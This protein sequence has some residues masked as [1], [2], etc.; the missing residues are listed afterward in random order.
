MLEET[1]GLDVL[2]VLRGPRQPP[3][4]VVTVAIDRETAS[5]FHASDEPSLWPRTLHAELV[6]RLVGA[7]AELVAF[8]VFFNEAR[9]DED[10]RLAEAI[11]EAG[12]VVLASFLKLKH[13]QGD[14]YVE[15]LVPPVETLASGALGSAPILLAQGAEAIRFLT[16]HGE[17]Q[18]LATWPLM[19]VNHYLKRRLQM[20]GDGQAPPTVPASS[21]RSLSIEEESTLRRAVEGL[22]EVTEKREA[23]Y[24]N[25]YGPAG[26]LTR[27]S[28]RD[29]LTV[30]SG[31][32][33]DLR[34]KI[35]VVGFGEDFQPDA[36]LQLGPYSALSSL[37]LA[38]TAVANLLENRPVRPL[39]NGAG[40]TLLLTV[41]G[42]GV[43][44]LARRA[45][46]LG[47]LG[48][49]LLAG[50]GYLGL[51]VLVFA[52]W[53]YWLPLMLPLFWLVPLGLLSGLLVNYLRHTSEKQRLHTAI[54]RFIPVEVAS[55]L[56][57]PEGRQDWD[58]RLRFGV[59]MACDAGQYTALAERMEPMALGKLMNAY[60]AALFPIM[61]GSG[62]WVSDVV[63]DAMMAIWVGGSE[64]DPELR[65]R[66]L[67]AALELQ[68][69]VDRFEHTYAVRL[70][71]RIGLHC[72][73]MRVGFIGA[74]DHGEYRAMGDTVN[75]AAR[76]E[77]LNKLLG[78]R[79]LASAAFMEGMEHLHR[80]VGSF[81]L[82]G[83]SQP[84]AVHEVPVALDEAGLLVYR[85]HTDRFRAALALFER[86]RWSEAAAAFEEL[87]RK[88]PDDGPVRFYCEAA[89]MRM[90]SP[91]GAGG[92]VSI[93][94]PKPLPAQPKEI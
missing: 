13:L 75:T 49:I 33:P 92:E 68:K 52:R 46:I 25:H 78:T 76:L 71:L 30:E 62:G 66:A 89:R 50:A 77:G 37:E 45:P 22:R 14:A 48:L 56:I 16:W 85:E 20:T 55:R 35:V 80:P 88:A 41:M 53:T 63:G 21:L 36:S 19:V 24:F 51:A 60:Y 43:G 38:A 26:T 1:V 8:T 90:R 23:R 87:G 70:P 54:Q 5:T 58:G 7:G 69:A 12:N 39:F 40:Q 79:I 42:M 4:Q 3:V 74:H 2:F 81:L 67:R 57:H 44:A 73:L 31:A 47:N 6:R 34:G 64:D 29:L 93:A 65:G 84:V 83:K 10:T 91:Q 28:C 17:R 94:V 72:G 86:G 27:L 11:D 18:I 9:P 32:L 61:T 59:C 15:M 82:A